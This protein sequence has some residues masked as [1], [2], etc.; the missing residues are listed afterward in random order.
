MMIN[1]IDAIVTCVLNF[2]YP[3]DIL[4]ALTYFLIYTANYFRNKT[5]YLDFRIDVK[6]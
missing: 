3:I 4:I 5:I 6:F 2:D 1:I